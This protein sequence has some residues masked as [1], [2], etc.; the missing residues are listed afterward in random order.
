MLATAN[1]RKLGGSVVLAAPRK[2]FALLVEEF[3]RL[4]LCLVALITQGGVFDGLEGF[5]APFCG[6]VIST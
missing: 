6:A 4:W 3:N 2:V 5:V 1:L